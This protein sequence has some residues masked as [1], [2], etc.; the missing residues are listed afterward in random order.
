MM[1]DGI[2]SLRKKSRFSLMGYESGKKIQKLGLDKSDTSCLFML[3]PRLL[4]HA[5]YRSGIIPIGLNLLS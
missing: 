2:L 1:A 4:F 3:D 5:L